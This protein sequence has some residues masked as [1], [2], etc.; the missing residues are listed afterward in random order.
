MDMRPPIFHGYT[1]DESIITF[2]DDFEQYAAVRTLTPAQQV[3]LLPVSLR[4]PARTAFTA[5]NHVGADAPATLLAMKAW[6]RNAYYTDEI[7]QALKDQLNTI[8]QGMSEDPNTFYTR[9]RH[10]IVLAD[11][12]DAVQDQVAENTFM[13]GIHQE[14]ALAI[15][16][17]P[18]VLDLVQKVT[19][20]QRY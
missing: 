11:Y 5:V 8:C 1:S 9:I 14:I 6:L 3:A 2:I 10:Q 16:S 20:T 15:R 4:G 17:I 7:K 18:M 12:P 19:Y 13:K